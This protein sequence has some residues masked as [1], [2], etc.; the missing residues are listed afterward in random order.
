[1]CLRVAKNAASKFGRQMRIYLPKLKATLAIALRTR[2]LL[3]TTNHHTRGSGNSGLRVSTRRPSAS[4][5]SLRAPN[6][7]SYPPL[8]YR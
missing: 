8:L 1:M 4:G 7:S 5:A 6:L 3:L 2:A